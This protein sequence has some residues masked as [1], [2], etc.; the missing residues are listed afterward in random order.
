[1]KMWAYLREAARGLVLVGLSVAVLASACSSNPDEPAAEADDTVIAR[2]ADGV[3]TLE[4]L[5]RA[6]AQLPAERPAPSVQHAKPPPI[7]WLLNGA[8]GVLT[9]TVVQRHA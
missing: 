1:M 5:D 7:F 4:D 8:L 3:V 6:I 9:Q 2:F